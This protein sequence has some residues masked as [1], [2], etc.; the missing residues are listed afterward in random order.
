MANH[1]LPDHALAPPSLANAD[2]EYGLTESVEAEET[3]VAWET[4]FT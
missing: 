2:F 3:F 4:L 1:G